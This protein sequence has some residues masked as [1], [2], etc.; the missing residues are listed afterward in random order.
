MTVSASVRDVP[1]S[2]TRPSST[3]SESASASGCATSPV[4]SAP[5]LRMRIDAIL[6]LRLSFVDRPQLVFQTIRHSEQVSDELL[7]LT[8]GDRCELQLA[9]LAVLE[10][11]SIFPGSFE[12]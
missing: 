4:T 10:E 12:R 3:Y 11:L 9:A 2:R 1:T 6:V 7:G 5:M 8:A